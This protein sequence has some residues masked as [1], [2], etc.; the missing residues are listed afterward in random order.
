MENKKQ[1]N[2][3]SVSNNFERPKLLRRDIKI[4][5]NKKENYLPSVFNIN[6]SV[7]KNS[8][9]TTSNINTNN[10]SIKTSHKSREIYSA[11]TRKSYN[12]S[13][14]KYKKFKN[15]DEVVIIL[16]RYVRKYLYRIHNE[17]KLQMIKMLKEKKRSLFENY[18]IIDKPSIIAGLKNESK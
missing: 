9:Q 5:N 6:K 10:K 15:I 14:K 8:L 13:K 2:K 16:Q 18:K 12:K 4:S 11:G 1:T 7:K 17:P 3:S